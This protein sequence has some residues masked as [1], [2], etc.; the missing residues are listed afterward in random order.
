M[1]WKLKSCRKFQPI[2]LFTRL[3]RHFVCYI[4]LK[5]PTPSLHLFWPLPRLLFWLFITTLNLSLTKYLSL[6]WFYLYRTFGFTVKI[7]AFSRKS[8]EDIVYVIV[9]SKPVQIQNAFKANPKQIH[10]SNTIGSTQDS[11]NTIK[12]RKFQISVQKNNQ[13]PIKY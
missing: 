12:K 13:I 9:Y 10:I 3:F 7:I 8:K 4:F 6:H 5:I 2:N 11:I 1:T